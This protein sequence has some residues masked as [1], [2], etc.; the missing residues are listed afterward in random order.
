M[1]KHDF[2]PQEIA[3]GL[4][5][6]A[7]VWERLL[8]TTGGALELSK[9]FYYIIAYDFNKNGVPVLLT[10]EAMPDTQISL[11]NGSDPTPILINQ[12][13]ANTAHVTLGVRPD[14]SGGTGDQSDFCFDRS[15]QI[16][17]GV[18]HSFMTRNEALMGYRHIWLPSVGYALA[19][20]PLNANQLHRV[21]VN[22]NNAFISKMGFCQKTC[23]KI[24]FGSKAFGGFGLTSLADFQGVNQTCLMV[25]H[26][27]L[28]DSVG[29]MLLIG[30]SWAQ[31]FCGVSFQILG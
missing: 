29:K 27:R 5:E 31:L 12:K 14:P 1:L 28:M 6:E 15:G 2:T 17:E 18:N 16:G 11:T 21:A 19:A 23:R 22:S 9:C 8:Y 20:W 4:Q 25:Q 3:I 13:D 7:Q 10:P 26:I 30:Y 24:I